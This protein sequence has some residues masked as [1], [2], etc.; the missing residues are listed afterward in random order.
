MKRKKEKQLTSYDHNQN[1]NHNQKKKFYTKDIEVVPQQRVEVIGRHPASSTHQ[2]SVVDECIRFH[3]VITLAF[4][5]PESD[6]SGRLLLCF[7]RI[8]DDHFRAF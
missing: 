2:M 1:H 3:S 4:S 8:I 6:L 7:A 5:Q